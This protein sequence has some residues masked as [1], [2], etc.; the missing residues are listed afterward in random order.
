MCRHI[1]IVTSIVVATL[2]LSCPGAESIPREIGPA[3]LDRLPMELDHGLATVPRGVLL[4]APATYSFGT[5]I[6]PE[7]SVYFTSFAERTITR[8]LPDQFGRP[9]IFS[10]IQVVAKDKPGAYGIVAGPKGDLFYGLDQGLGLGEIRHLLPEGSES[11]IMSGLTRPR[12]LALGSAGWLYVVL[13]TGQ[14]R[15]WDPSNEQTAMLIDQLLTPQSVAVLPNGAVY[16]SQY[17]AHSGEPGMLGTPRIG[18]TLRCLQPGQTTELLAGGTVKQFW[19][20]R[21][22]DLGP[23]GEVVF[24]TE[25]N[26]WD[27]GNSGSL[28]RFDPHSRRL[29]RVL[30]GLDYPQ[31]TSVGPDGRVYFT[32]ARDGWLAVYD[33]NA[34]FTDQTMPGHGNVQMSVC[35]GRWLAEESDQ[36]GHRITLRV[37]DLQFSGVI[38]P[39]EGRQT[40]GGWIRIPASRFPNLSKQPLEH[41]PDPAAGMFPTPSVRISVGCGRCKGAALPVRR[42]HRA[43]FP[44]V[45]DL[46]TPPADFDET[47]IAYLVFFQWAAPMEDDRE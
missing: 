4:V 13:E 46:F 18:G 17:S 39:N 29:T 26:V 33:P 5:T 36:P 28:C 35:G 11:T 23:A 27:Q 43:R 12:Q 30:T 10:E 16:F 47:P 19:R 40:I 22:I 1:E 32:F 41:P 37:E 2:V 6:G 42:H 25:A 44:F 7:N 31:A 9:S 14:I 15:T 34:R 24:V 21:D 45:K 20:T 8:V 3:Y 38:L